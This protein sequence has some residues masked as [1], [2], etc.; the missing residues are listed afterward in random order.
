[1]L[2]WNILMALITNYKYRNKNGENIQFL[3]SVARSD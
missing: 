1:M 3:I 2:N